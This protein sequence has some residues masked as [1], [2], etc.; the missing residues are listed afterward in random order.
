MSNSIT[1]SLMTKRRENAKKMAA[2]AAELMKEKNCDLEV[3]LTIPV[4]LT[5]FTK[6]LF[7]FFIGTVP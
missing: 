1:I 4:S 3:E 7:K 5:S 6:Q 2:R